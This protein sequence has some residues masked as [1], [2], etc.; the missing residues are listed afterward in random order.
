MLF[1]KGIVMTF[2]KVG[3]C[4]CLSYLLYTRIDGHTFILTYAMMIYL[5][6]LSSNANIKALVAILAVHVFILYEGL[7]LAYYLTKDVL[8][9]G[10]LIGD[11]THNIVMALSYLALLFSIFY[12]EEV[13]RFFYRGKPF[14]YMP[15]KADMVQIFITKILFAF[16]F[17]YTSVLAYFAIKH[18]I[19]LDTDPEA[20][21][22]WYDKFSEHVLIHRDYASNLGTIKLFTFSLLL[23]SWSSQRSGGKRPTYKGTM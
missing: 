17:F 16:A 23:V 6:T 11:L 15:T 22:Y 3:V 14:I 20:A 13:T 2:L 18:S 4:L 5:F 9:T 10:K 8:E 19:S 1:H 21:K 7:Y 12:R